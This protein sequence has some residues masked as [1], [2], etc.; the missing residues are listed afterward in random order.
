MAYI[1]RALLNGAD[2][3]FIGGC[4]LN[5]CHYI[6]HGNYYALNMVHLARR[7]MEHAGVHPDRLRM[8]QISGG[9]GVRFAELVDAFTDTVTA[10]G[11]IGESG[12]AEAADWRERLQEVYE[13]VPYIK[14]AKR[15]KLG[16]R[17]R[18]VEESRALFPREEVEELLRD[19]PSY[20]IDPE[21]C[22]ACM[23]C[24]KRC[25]VDAIE[26]GKNRIHVIDQEACIRCGTCFEACPPRFGAVTRVCGEPVPPPLAEEERVLVRASKAG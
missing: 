6:T 19:V 23:I 9:E 16:Q 5:D 1:F 17:F 21:K 25:P 3:V 12:G 2:G 8:E 24:A 7:L 14:L 10:L 26:G 18:D 13:L 20:Y 11:P 15:D 4:Y 22:R